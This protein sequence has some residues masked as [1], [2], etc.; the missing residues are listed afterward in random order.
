MM[1]REIAG[2][3]ILIPVG[4]LAL[5]VHGMVSLSESGRLLWEK[6]QTECSIQELTDAVLAE[7]EIDSETAEKDVMEFLKKLEAIGVLIQNGGKL[8]A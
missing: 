4:A 1:L 5:K 7:Y 2:E 3:S 8:E 6:L